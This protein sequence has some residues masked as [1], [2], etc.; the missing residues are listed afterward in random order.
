MPKG[1]SR[2]SGADRDGN[3]GRDV[4]EAIED[5]AI[6]PILTDSV[7][8]Q[9]TPSGG[10]GP[11]LPITQTAE[12]AIRQ[13][14]GWKYRDGDAKGVMQAL[15]NSFT[16]T[17]EQGHTVVNWTPRSYA[18]VVS[19]DLGEVT[20]AQASI[21][22]RA[23]VALDQMLPLLD[24][25]KGLRPDFDMPQGDAMRAIV[26]TEVNELVAELGTVGGPR[27]Q[28]VNELFKLLGGQPWDVRKGGQGAAFDTVK[29][30]LNVLRERFGLE[31]IFVNTIDD[32]KDLTNFV[33]AVDYLNGLYL[34]WLQE[35]KFFEGGKGQAF[36]GTQLVLI[37]RALAVVAETVQTVYFAM[38]SVYLSAAERA[39]VPLRFGKGHPTLTLAEFLTW[40]E[41]FASVEAQELI[42]EGGKDGVVAFRNTL[43]LLHELS[44]RAQPGNQR[45]PD[46]PRAFQTPRVKRA[47]QELASQ[48]D[49][50]LKLARGINRGAAPVVT[51]AVGSWKGGILRLDIA[52][53]NFQDGADAELLLSDAA[54]YEDAAA[55]GPQAL[56]P[57]RAPTVGGTT[58]VFA[59]F[60]IHPSL[61]RVVPPLP[62]AQKDMADK[63]KAY[64]DA[65]AL[66]GKA[67]T[68]LKDAVAEYQNAR[69]A[70][71][72]NA[73]DQVVRD[74]EQR[75]KQANEV[76]AG[77]LRAKERATRA[78]VLERLEYGKAFVRL[79]NPDE[80]F[81]TGLLEIPARPASEV[82]F[83]TILSS[84][85]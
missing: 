67:R 34:G 4:I 13:V 69:A 55:N 29:G 47:L 72:E 6:Y 46:V 63:D 36:L 26:R 37:S 77:A 51:G 20:G 11:G 68:E 31:T 73:N 38:D 59:E 57:L 82:D 83:D 14:L 9:P 22:A 44:M 24:G 18:A 39:V 23:K 64:R 60:R 58:S 41:R 28:R 79:T 56:Q 43:E 85:D 42:N 1:N 33:M 8:L 53:A 50:A 52:G 80:Q 12:T 70:D 61:G 32:E 25:L 54:S 17:E 19:A 76:V 62:I 66:R 27:V 5:V 10:G 15:N 2:R 65:L 78:A 7:T 74:A 21:Y 45:R 71:P 48:L 84:Q 75:L 3:D 40:V 49:D 16:V 30:H 81:G 35:K